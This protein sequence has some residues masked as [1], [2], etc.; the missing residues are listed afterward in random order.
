ME[1]ETSSLIRT[2]R[3]SDQYKFQCEEITTDAKRLDEQ[4]EGITWVIAR[5]PDS[6][7]KIFNAEGDVRMIETEQFPGAPKLLVL[8][9][10]D[11]SNYCT[12][13]W[14]ETIPSIDDE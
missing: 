12:L 4:L 9:T 5:K 8:F 14:I 13:Q 2:L 7:T 10:I 6:C 11:D 1:T 3:E